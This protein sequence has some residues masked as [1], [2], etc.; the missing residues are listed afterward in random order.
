MDDEGGS[1]MS[2]WEKWLVNLK[3]LELDEETY[4]EAII[5][6]LMENENNES[7]KEKRIMAW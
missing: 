2:D 4:R 7:E 6:K 5:E 3:A 1:E